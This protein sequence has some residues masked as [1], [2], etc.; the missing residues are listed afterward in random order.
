MARLIDMPALRA[1]AVGDNSH[2]ATPGP[3]TATND[4]T[5]TPAATEAI[6]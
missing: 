3:S 1:S 4:T 2:T 5:A 6:K